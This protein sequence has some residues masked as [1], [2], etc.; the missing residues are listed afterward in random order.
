[1]L[2]LYKRITDNYFDMGNQSGEM[3][4][5]TGINLG[6]GRTATA[7]SAGQYHSCSL[8]DNASVK[9]WGE[10]TNGE[11]GIDNTTKECISTGACWMGNSVGEMGLL[12]GID[13]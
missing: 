5:L 2:Q 12:L 9:W 1:M 7:I 13:L 3:A 8:L 10:N 11:L 6:P 4:L